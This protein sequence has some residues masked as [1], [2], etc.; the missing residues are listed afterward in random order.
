MAHVFSTPGL[1]CSTIKD[2]GKFY[3][4]IVMNAWYHKRLEWQELKVMQNLQNI[5]NKMRKLKSHGNSEAS[6]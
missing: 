1:V 4:L 3:D 5:I 6:T 2:E